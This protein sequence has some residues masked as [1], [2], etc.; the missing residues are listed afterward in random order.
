MA[1]VELSGGFVS[2]RQ[3][4]RQID[5]KYPVNGMATS[6]GHGRRRLDVTWEQK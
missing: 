2:S 4:I 3:F 1:C 6:S 5:G